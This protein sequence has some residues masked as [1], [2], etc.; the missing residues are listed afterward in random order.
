MHFLKL[1]ERTARGVNHTVNHGLQLVITHAQWF[2]SR[3]KGTT[4]RQDAEDRGHLVGVV[5][6]PLCYVLNFL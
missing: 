3:N 2:I 1:T 6:D 5:W 4:P